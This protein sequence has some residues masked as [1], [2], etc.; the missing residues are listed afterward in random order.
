MLSRWKTWAAA[1]AVAGAALVVPAPQAAAQA[2]QIQ[3]FSI[4]LGPD[5]GTVGSN[6]SITVTVV[7]VPRNG[8]S[9]TIDLTV[10]GLTTGMDFD[11]SR[12]TLE[13]GRSAQLTI[14]GSGDVIFDPPRRF[15]IV[16]RGTA[17][18]VPAEHAVF[19]LLTSG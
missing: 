6:T 16:I 10:S 1:L 2:S 3:Q 19:Q 4:K 13:P 5:S 12:T 15:G 14:A 17:A 18:G 9:P 11:L 8:F 7:N